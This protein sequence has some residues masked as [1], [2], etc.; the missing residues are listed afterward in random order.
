MDDQSPAPQHYLFVVRV[1]PEKTKTEEI[2]W[3]GR[4]QSATDGQVRYFQGW[5]GLVKMLAIS[6]GDE[7]TMGE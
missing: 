6:V 4:I 3:R 1:W 5:E 2:V 7:E